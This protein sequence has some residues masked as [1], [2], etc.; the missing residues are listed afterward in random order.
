MGKSKRELHRNLSCPNS[1]RSSQG[2][3]EQSRRKSQTAAKETNQ[4]QRQTACPKTC[5]RRPLQ[6]RKRKKIGIKMLLFVIST[7]ITCMES[8]SKIDN[9]TRLIPSKRKKLTP[10]TTVLC[11]SDCNM[12]SLITF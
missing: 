9:T 4:G 12:N 1:K 8:R 5:L 2:K 10:T 6:K 11:G 7:V 3:E